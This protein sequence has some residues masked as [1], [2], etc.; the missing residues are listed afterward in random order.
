MDNNLFHLIANLDAE[1]TVPDDGIVSRTIYQDD[2]VKAVAFGFSPGQELSE[3]TAA[4]P[5]IMHFISGHADITVGD[6][7]SQAGPG[8]WV[9]MKPHVPHSVVATEKTVMLLLLIKCGKVAKP[10]AESGN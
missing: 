3:H 5:G 2:H 1:V 8:T 7:P 9:A 6:S 10:A 4:M